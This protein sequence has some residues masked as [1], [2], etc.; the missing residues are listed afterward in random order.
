MTHGW[1]RALVGGAVEVESAGTEP[2]G[3]VPAHTPDLVDLCAT[4]QFD[5]VLTAIPVAQ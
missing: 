2:T 5:L 3:D 4:E 1:L